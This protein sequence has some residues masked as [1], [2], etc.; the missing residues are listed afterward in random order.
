MKP[1]IEPPAFLE[2]FKH[3]NP[4]TPK[5]NL[6]PIE[7]PLPAGNKNTGIYFWIIL[8]VVCIVGGKLVIDHLDKKDKTNLS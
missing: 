2:A 4:I 3:A 6:V 1:L 5:I 7:I 8:G